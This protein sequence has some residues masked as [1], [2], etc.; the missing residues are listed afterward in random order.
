M[1]RDWTLAT[2]KSH[3]AA[4]PF[5]DASDNPEL[6]QHDE[7]DTQGNPGS[8]GDGAL[9][10]AAG[11]RRDSKPARRGARPGR[12]RRTSTRSGSSV[13]DRFYDPRLNGLDWQE[14][15]PASARKPHPRARVKTRRR[16]I[17]AMLAKLG[18]SHTHYYTP[19]GS[20]LLPARRYFRRRARASR[21]RAGLP[22][23]A[24]YPIRELACSPRPT[25]RAASS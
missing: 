22:Q 10:R 5:R 25:I 2:V 1:G 7:S 6:C 20:G 3:R 19:D 23:R 18:A 15:A 24:R 11:E 14:S 21:P 8:C 4:A 9:E 17:N 16:S 12:I 13:R